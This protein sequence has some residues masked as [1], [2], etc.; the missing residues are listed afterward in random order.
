MT[1]SKIPATVGILT[2]N[3]QKT[4]KRCLESVKN[5]EEIIICDGNST[6][7]TLKIARSYGCKVIPQYKSNKKNIKMKDVSALRNKTMK[8]A[9]Y[10]WFFFV[11]SDDYISNKLFNSIAKVALSRNSQHLLYR[12]NRKIKIGSKLIKYS[13]SYPDAVIILINKKT[14]AKFYKKVHEK[15]KYDNSKFSVGTLN[16]LMYRCWSKK[17]AK[18][19]YWKT[20]NS[21]LKI[22]YLSSKDK[23]WADY[24]RWTLFFNLK[25]MLYFIIKP[26][27]IY[28]KYGF[29]ESMPIKIELFRALYHGKILW[30]ITT[31]K[32]KKIL[33]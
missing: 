13:A 16:G 3:S 11:D 5:F 1:K 33:K 32:V 23:T 19:E 28:I 24:F 21:H 15:L 7:N 22:E 18:K 10:N 12:I 2:L 29:K 4:L 27:L 17:R 30:M 8:A 26:L 9:I 14:K 31:Y 20:A 6:D 25:T